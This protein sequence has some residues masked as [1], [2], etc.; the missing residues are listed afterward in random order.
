MHGC[1][2]KKGEKMIF[3]YPLILVAK[4]EFLESFQRG[5]LYM[6]NCLHYQQLEK[7]DSKRG[8]K[9]DGAVKCS[10]N[11]YTINKELLRDVDDPRIMILATYVKCFNHFKDNDV[12]KI[13]DSEYCFTFSKESSDEFN[14]FNQEY[15][16]IIYDVPKFI[17]RFSNACKSNKNIDNHFYSDVI[18]ID[19]EEYP[20]YEEDLI[21]G[22]LG[23]KADGV[24][25]PAFLKRK[26][27]SPQQEFRIVVSL[28]IGKPLANATGIKLPESIGFSMNGIEDISAIVKLSEIA[29]KTIYAKIVKSNESKGERIEYYL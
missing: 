14:S 2:V 3:E 26:R 24:V 27:Y 20:K 25:N 13:S 23:K 8:D 7:D 9:Y 15:A 11:G 17:E 6:V 4:K 22:V 1:S 28:N 16:L 21:S 19:D 10:Y 18:Y 5:N 29:Q 12:Q